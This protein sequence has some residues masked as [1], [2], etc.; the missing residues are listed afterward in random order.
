MT[1][2]QGTKELDVL[3]VG[4]GFSGMYLIHK[5]RQNGFSVLSV[6]AASDIG[7]TWYHN[8]YPGL[9]CD[10]ESLEY[11]YTFSEQIRNEWNWSERYPPQTEIL[12]Y[13]NFVAEKLDL[14]RDI[15]LNTRIISAHWN[16][17]EN[18][19]L[20]TS[21]GGQTW[22]PRWVV[23]GTG[24]LSMPRYPN[25]PGIDKFKG[26]LIHTADWPESGAELDAKSVGLIGTGSSGVQVATAIAE[27]TGKLSVFQRSPAYTIPA[28]NR[29]LSDTDRRTFRDNFAELDAWARSTSGGIMTGPAKVSALEV[30]DDV[31][32]EMLMEAWGKGGS[33]QFTATFNDIKNNETANDLVSEFVRERIRETVANPK[34]AELLCPTD[35][36]ATR[37]VCVD[38]GYFEIFNRDNVSLVDVAT[39]PIVAITADGVKLASGIEHK[40]DVLVLATGYDAMTGALLAIDIQGKDAIPLKDAW[41]EGPKTYLGL[42]VAGFPNLFTVTGPGSPSVLSNVLRSIEHH[43]EWITDCL[44]TMRDDSKTRIEAD[45]T[46]QEDWV[47]RVNEA[48]EKTLFTKAASWYMGADIPGKPRVFMPYAGGLPTYVGICN[49]VV[50]QGYSGFNR[51]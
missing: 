43:V 7:G 17:A 38:T 50:E 12:K 25:I 24:C 37:R 3:V 48:A 45:D 14:R 42:S 18:R 26:T 30:S 23:M 33:F 34:T 36:I 31:R 1:N 21:E 47:L 9:R 41:A 4:A 10:V 40:L 15:Q 11:S 32:N 22:A 16:E 51:S 5:M 46:A 20:V 13:A 29:P 27:R 35:F 44:V 19:W 28:R 2:S 49:K 6:D 8:R 39:D